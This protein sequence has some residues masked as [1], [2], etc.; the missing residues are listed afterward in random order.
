MLLNDQETLS[1][2]TVCTGWTGGG[3]RHLLCFTDRQC[4]PRVVVMRI[5]PYVCVQV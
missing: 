1:V 4:L 3:L 5:S 2:T